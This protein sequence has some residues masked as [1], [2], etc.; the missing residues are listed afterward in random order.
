[1]ISNIFTDTPYRCFS[2]SH[3]YTIYNSKLMQLTENESP[4]IQIYILIFP[5]YFDIPQIFRYPCNCVFSK[6]QLLH[7]DNLALVFFLC[8]STFNFFGFCNSRI[9]LWDLGRLE[10]HFFTTFKSNISTTNIFLKIVQSGHII[11]RNMKIR[12]QT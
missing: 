5:K 8:D 2:M 1:M 4:S 11:Y 10:M 7:C 12:V 3:E 6:F 9:L